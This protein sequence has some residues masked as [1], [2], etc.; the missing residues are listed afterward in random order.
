MNSNPTNADE[1][2]ELGNEYEQGGTVDGERV[3][4]DPDKAIYWFTKAAEQN[5][6]E[7]Q[8]ALANL[9][10]SRDPQKHQYWMNKSIENRTK[11]YM[12][13]GQKS[14]SGCYVATCVYGSYDC[15]EVWTLRRFRD[16]ILSNS[17]FGKGFIRVYYAVSPKIVELFGNTKL[18]NRLWKPILNKFV[19]KLQN[20]G[21]D[22]SPYSDMQFTKHGSHSEV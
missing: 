10:Y 16:N 17:W 21:M 14:N 22:S 13:S 1:Q 2:Y 8:I 9:Y 20:N 18:F 19:C 4:Y 12:D 15:P 11:Y 7:A 6:Y 3:P 5:H